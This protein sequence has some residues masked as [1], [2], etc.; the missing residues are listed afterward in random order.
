[1]LTQLLPRELVQIVKDYSA[2]HLGLRIKNELKLEIA[3]R[4]NQPITISDERLSEIIS[5]AQPESPE[6][7]NNEDDETC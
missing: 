4:S 1:M 6:I 3:S 5:T 2:I 7:I